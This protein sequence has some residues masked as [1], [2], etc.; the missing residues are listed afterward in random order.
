LAQLFTNLIDNALNH[1]PPG[2]RIWSQLFVRNGQ[3]V[4]SI[5]DDGP[6]IPIKERIN[7]LG[8]FYRLDRSRSLPG[9]G[10]GLA[11]VA[12]I[13]ALHEAKLT[14]EDNRPGLCVEIVFPKPARALPDV[15]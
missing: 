5:C 15:E 12:A 9:S 2:T 4:V 7:V 3:V 6:G 10:L 8:R 13:A 1:T 14:L 11:L